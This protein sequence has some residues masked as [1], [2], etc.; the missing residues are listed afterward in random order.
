MKHKE[1]LPQDYLDAHVPPS[2]PPSNGGGHGDRPRGRKPTR[3]RATYHLPVDLVEEL[4]DTVVALSGPPLRL[5]VA[6]TVA[7]AVRD[8]LKALRDKHN[9]GERFPRRAGNL[10]GGR[11]IRDPKDE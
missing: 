8:R 10:Q 4:R 11:P 5:T 1:P 9:N 6:G 2:A 7:G 3:V